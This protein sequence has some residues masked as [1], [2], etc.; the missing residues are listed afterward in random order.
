MSDY[1]CSLMALIVTIKKET[2]LFQI[3]LIIYVKFPEWTDYL[4]LSSS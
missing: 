3:I 2:Y 4:F 1:S